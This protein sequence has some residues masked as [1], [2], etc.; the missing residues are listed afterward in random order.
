MDRRQ[1]TNIDLPLDGLSTLDVDAARAAA[2]RQR[3]H[4]IVRRQAAQVPSRPSRARRFEPALVSAA[5]VI[6]LGEVARRAWVILG[7]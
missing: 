1:G 7:M 3:C 2:L 6:F 4:D 5:A